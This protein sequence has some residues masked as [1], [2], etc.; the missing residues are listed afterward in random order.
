M[1]HLELSDD[2]ILPIEAVTQ[3][4]AI[5]AK[6]RVGK[7][8]TASVMAEEMV[9]AGLPWVAIDPTG[10]WWGLRS[11]ADGMSPGLPV[12]I[13]GGAHG[14]LPLEPGSGKVIAE[15]VV[16]NPAH[17]ILDLSETK[18]NAEQDRFACE[19]AEVLYR[20]K[21]K[22]PQP[23]HIFVDEAD[24]FIPQRPMPGQQR[25]LGAFET[26]IR[27]GGIRGIG[28]TIITQRPAVVNKNVLTQAEVLIVLQITSP[29]DREAIDAWVQGHGTKDQRDELVG[30]LAS[31]GKGEA[32]F[33]SPAWLDVF[34][35]VKIRERETFNSS[36]TP[37]VGGA[38]W[39]LSRLPK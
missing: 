3:T 2:L 15:L 35:R 24:A 27:R 4:F 34:K 7:T 33:W 29:Q 19:F 31:M 37:E 14:D 9:K 13:I 18:S 10:A 12:I 16:S 20:L 8:Y 17:Y 30:S 25:M 36:A 39:R 1:D 26:L 23:L 11:S 6:R 28:M 22:S 21:G 32:W 38:S 5:L